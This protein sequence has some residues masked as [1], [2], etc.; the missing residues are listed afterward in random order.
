[1]KREAPK[2]SRIGVDLETR[3]SNGESYQ[4]YP[5]PTLGLVHYSNGYSAPLWRSSGDVQRR[6]PWCFLF[7]EGTIC[8]PNTACYYAITGAY[9]KVLL[10]GWQDMSIISPTYSIPIP[11]CWT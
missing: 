9:F 8:F 6:E 3:R 10:R 11:Q 4:R 7:V 5:P 2:E 1:M